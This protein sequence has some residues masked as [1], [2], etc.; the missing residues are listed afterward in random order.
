MQVCTQCKDHK[1][2]QPDG[3][4]GD[5]TA[6]QRSIWLEPFVVRQALALHHLR[7]ARQG[8]TCSRA[9]VRLEQEGHVPFVPKTAVN[10]P[11]QH[12]ADP[13]VERWIAEHCVLLL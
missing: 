2:L 7:F 13:E 4:C 11:T 9:P 6:L 5:A 8:T 1:F 10:V 3:T 12:M